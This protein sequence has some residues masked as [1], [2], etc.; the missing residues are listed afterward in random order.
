MCSGCLLVPFDDL[1]LQKVKFCQCECVF[2]K[3][4]LNPCSFLCEEC[5][6]LHVARVK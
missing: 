5:L 6:H 4:Y 3:H 2:T 1:S